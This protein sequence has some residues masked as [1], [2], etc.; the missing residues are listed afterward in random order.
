M[1]KVT[2]VAAPALGRVKGVE[3]AD[4]DIQGVNV[5]A[6]VRIS[7]SCGRVVYRTRLESERAG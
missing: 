7:W 2:T 5:L 3:L 1:T 4:P 6:G